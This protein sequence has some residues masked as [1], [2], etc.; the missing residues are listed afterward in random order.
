M[1]QDFI[2]DF[3]LFSMFINGLPEY[4]EDKRFCIVTNKLFVQISI[5]NVLSYKKPTYAR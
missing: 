4:K 3:I 1:I 5:P 2:I